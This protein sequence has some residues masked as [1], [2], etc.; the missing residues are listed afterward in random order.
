MIARLPP[1]S[2][3]HPGERLSLHPRL[4]RM[5]LFDPATGRAI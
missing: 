3:H 1:G 4:D 5:H 2:V